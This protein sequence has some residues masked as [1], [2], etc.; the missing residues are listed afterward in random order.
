MIKAMLVGVLGFV[1]GVAALAVAR[2]LPEARA[3]ATPKLLIMKVDPDSSSGK[4]GPITSLYVSNPGGDSQLL[5]RMAGAA[6]VIHMASL[7]DALSLRAQINSAQT[8]SISCVDSSAHYV[9]PS[10]PTATQYFI[11][12]T[13]P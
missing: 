10:P 1:A 13:A 6:C 11:L 9:L 7:A 2:G 8:S 3:Q 5:I 12:N 4:S